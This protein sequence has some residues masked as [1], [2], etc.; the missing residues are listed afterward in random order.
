MIAVLFVTRLFDQ[1]SAVVPIQ[2][3]MFVVLGFTPTV[4]LIGLLHARLARST[5]A[6]LVVEL[7]SGRAARCAG[8]VRDPSLERVYWLRP[9]AG[10]T[11]AS[12]NAWRSAT[13]PC[14]CMSPASSKGASR[15]RAGTIIAA[16]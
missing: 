16:F 4:F 6:G 3:F 11:R 13:G 12:P 5:V 14:T 9:R 1:A 8:A 10:P 15:P 2:R 7:L